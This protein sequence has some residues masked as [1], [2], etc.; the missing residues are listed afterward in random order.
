MVACDLL[1]GFV[2]GMAAAVFLERLERPKLTIQVGNGNNQDDI[3][4][5]P[6][7]QF[8][9]LFVHNVPAWKPLAGRKPAWSSQAHLSIVSSD[10]A[11]TLVAPI[12]ARW[13]SQ[14][15]PV[16]CT[17]QGIPQLD[18]A[19]IIA[20][21][22]VDIHA[23]EAQALV[24]AV[25]T[26]NDPDVYLFTNESYAFPHLSNPDWKLTGTK[27]RIRVTVEYERGSEQRDFWIYN[28]GHRCDDVY[29]EPV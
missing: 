19:R 14:P 26:K 29:L 2:S 24:V 18:V 13:N 15:D 9:H 21:R 3:A 8:Y 6:D 25:K 5:V 12:P 20:G 22:K 28:R 4:N 1:I 10:G 17:C 23:H 27:H 11:S 7:R 16:T